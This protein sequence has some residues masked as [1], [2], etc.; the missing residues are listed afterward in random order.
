[1]DN[2]LFNKYLRQFTKKLKEY[3]FNRQ[4]TNRFVRRT[5][6]DIVQEILIQRLSSGGR[7]T[8]NYD[9]FILYQPLPGRFL[10]NTRNTRFDKL[11]PYNKEF[12]WPLETDEDC[13]KAFNDFYDIFVNIVFPILKQYEKKEVLLE[14][15]AG[16]MVNFKNYIKILVELYYKNYDQAKKDYEYALNNVESIFTG[17]KVF[18]TDAYKRLLKIPKEVFSDPQ[19]SNEYLTGNIKENIEKLKLPF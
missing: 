6:N 1:M 13:E 2:K 15:T 16:G 5:D 8:A 7:I 14:A 19:K 18:K 9:I 12:W 17:D 4:G 3:G 11:S 10:G